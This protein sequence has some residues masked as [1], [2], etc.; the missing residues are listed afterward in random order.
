MWWDHEEVGNHVHNHFPLVYL[1]LVRAFC[2]PGG[3]W[4]HQPKPGLGPLLPS[5]RG[6]G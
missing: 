4:P 1:R 2:K 6:F 3:K 5:V